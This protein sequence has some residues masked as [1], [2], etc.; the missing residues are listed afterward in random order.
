MTDAGPRT[1]VDL[2]DTDLTVASPADDIRGMSVVDRHGEDVGDVDGLLIDEGERRVRFL[3]VGSGGFLGIGKKKR[4]IP[5]DAITDI[6]DT[7]HVDTTREHIA[8]SPD[9][10]PDVVEKPTF[11][12]YYD[13]YDYPPFWAPGYAYPAYP[14]RVM[15]RS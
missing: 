8:G 12:P 15:P 6:E 1:L 14:Y 3:M 5:V 2:D 7:V 13:Y 11:E 9:Y 4:L 10:D